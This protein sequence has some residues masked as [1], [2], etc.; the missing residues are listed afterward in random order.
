MAFIAPAR[1]G[2]ST[3]LLQLR[4]FAV[5]GQLVT[6]LIAQ[7]ITTTS[8]PI[9]A[10]LLLVGLTALTNFLYGGWLYRISQRRGTDAD[11]LHR[12]A[13]VL[14]AFDLVILT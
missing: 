7:S 13:F 12:V 3:W 1:F 5:V 10:L 14:M 4:T 9:I 6:I 11:R 2:S 8:L